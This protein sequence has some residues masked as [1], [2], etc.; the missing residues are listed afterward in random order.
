MSA[1][2]VRAGA[3]GLNTQRLPRGETRI[4]SAQPP[5]SRT[6]PS[7]VGGSGNG[8]QPATDRTAPSPDL[9][10]SLPHSSL[11]THHSSLIT[12]STLLPRRG[13]EL[14]HADLRLLAARQVLH[15]HRLALREFASD[16][17]RPPRAKG[18]G[19]L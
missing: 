7:A 6:E 15:N 10:G 17:D 3:G 4:L 18:T 11:I 16:D 8:R 12:F 14:L 19:L 9:G 13:H 5:S 2:P 1:I